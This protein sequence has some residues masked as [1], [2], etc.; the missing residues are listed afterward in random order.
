M[1]CLKQPT[2]ADW[3]AQALTDIDAVLADHAHCEMKAASNALSLIARYPDDLERTRIL[4]ELAS[5]EIGHF[6]RV[7][8]FLLSRGIP[9]GKPGVDTYA[10]E[11]RRQARQPSRHRFD[12]PPLVDRLLVA[13]LIEARSCERFRLLVEA[14]T[15]HRVHA[16]LSALWKEL[17]AAEAGHY[18]TFVD[19]A[20]RAAGVDAAGVAARLEQLAELEGG[21]VTRLATSVATAKGRASIHG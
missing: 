13:A 14:T 21:I 19:L 4:G 3:A 2:D 1:L 5:E 6:Q 7:M 9:L 10:A 16:D 17:F 20:I 12:N 18:R 11:L 8:G 15:T